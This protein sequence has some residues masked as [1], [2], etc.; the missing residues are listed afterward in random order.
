MKSFL[1]NTKK[2]EREYI[3]MDKDSYNNYKRATCF[4]IDIEPVKGVIDI[5]EE[6]LI[7][8]LEENYNIDR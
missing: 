7:S 5:K 6:T 3:I 1:I 2:G 4:L 8:I